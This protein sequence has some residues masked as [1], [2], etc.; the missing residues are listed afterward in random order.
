MSD[1]LLKAKVSKAARRV[2]GNIALTIITVGAVNSEEFLE[3][4]KI[5]DKPGNLF[6]SASPIDPNHVPDYK[7][8]EEG[9]K[10]P[11]QRQRNIIYALY[12]HWPQKDS[13]PFDDYYRR[14]MEVISNNLKDRLPEP[15]F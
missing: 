10:T 6:F 14:V 15:L 13:T 5:L 7:P 4:D 12:Q 2:D 11:S 3:I 9:D 8:I 1:I